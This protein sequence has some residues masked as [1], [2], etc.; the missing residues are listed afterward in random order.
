MTTPSWVENVTVPDDDQQAFAALTRLNDEALR[1]VIDALSNVDVDA[2]LQGLEQRL[3]KTGRVEDPADIA[4][5]LLGFSAFRLK[6]GISSR[7]GAD[8]VVRSLR[9]SDI[10]PGAT[11]IA[12]ILAADGLVAIAKV[13]DLRHAYPIRY[14]GGRVITELRP[15]F[16]EPGDDVTGAIIVHQLIIDS[17]QDDDIIDRTITMTDEDLIRLQGQITRAL[18]KSQTLSAVVKRG[19]IPIYGGQATSEGE[20]QKND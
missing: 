13:S 20:T 3:A 4:S 12:P 10:T 9:E 15:I 6:H 18:K 1:A 16:D 17:Y 8:A 11:D 2:G 19:S 5:S 7:Q 14:F